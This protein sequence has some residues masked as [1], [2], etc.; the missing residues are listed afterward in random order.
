MD[1]RRSLRNGW[2]RHRRWSAHQPLAQ[3]RSVLRAFIREIPS[4]EPRWISRRSY[5][6]KPAWKKSRVTIGEGDDEL[7]GAEIP[8]LAWLENGPAFEAIA[9]DERGGP[10]RLVVPDPRVFLVRFTPVPSAPP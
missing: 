6:A 9:I 8:G 1:A 4:G 7:V 5:Q 3:S 10:L 2:Q